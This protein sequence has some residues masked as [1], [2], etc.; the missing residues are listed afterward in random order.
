LEGFHVGQGVFTKKKNTGKVSN[1]EAQLQILSENHN[2][3]L[4][5]SYFDHF[6]RHGGHGVRKPSKRLECLEGF[7]FWVNYCQG[8]Q[9]LTGLAAAG[10]VR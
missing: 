9:P 2:F 10:R 6:P 1:R 5:L 4:P 7:L 8:I 3:F